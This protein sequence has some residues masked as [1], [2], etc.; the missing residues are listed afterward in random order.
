[1]KKGLTGFVLFVAV[2]LAGTLTARAAANKTD[3][4]HIDQDTLAS[5]VINISI[6]AV[7]KHLA[8]HSDQILDT[9]VEF[10][11]DG[12]DN[13]CDGIEQKSAAL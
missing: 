3:V 6:K 13:D 11:G 4:C 2:I 12:I 9:A 10:C 8:L 5:H 1:M 7:D